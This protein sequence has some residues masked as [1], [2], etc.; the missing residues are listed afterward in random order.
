ME[1]LQLEVIE[2]GNGFCIAAFDESLGDFCRL[3]KEVY[4]LFGT[5]RDALFAGTW[6]IA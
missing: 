1:I 6:T 2:T 5:A 4:G 3:S